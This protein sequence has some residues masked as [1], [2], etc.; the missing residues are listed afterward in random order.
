MGHLPA[1]SK[2]KRLCKDISGTYKDMYGTLACLFRYIHIRTCMGHKISCEDIS[3]TY[4][5][6][7]G[8][9]ACLLQDQDIM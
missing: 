8:T 7:Y 1:S 5:D 6:M 9:L 3:G 2:I 4:K